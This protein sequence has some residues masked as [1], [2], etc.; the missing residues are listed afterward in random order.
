MKNTFEPPKVTGPSNSKA[1]NTDIFSMLDANNKRA[2]GIRK[3]VPVQVKR[4]EETQT[5]SDRG[6]LPDISIKRT[7]MARR[8]SVRVGVGLKNL[9]SKQIMSEHVSQ[10]RMDAS[11]GE[12][13]KSH[14]SLGGT[15]KHS[16]PHVS[17]KVTRRRGD[18]RARMQDYIKHY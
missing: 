10:P 17:S 5:S 6:T 16:D 9:I 12:V 1:L 7:S 8:S 15:D 3:V 14:R 4:L 2:N 13:V 11:D 18:L